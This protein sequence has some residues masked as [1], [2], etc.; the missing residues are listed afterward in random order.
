MIR[1]LPSG[2]LS[3]PLSTRL[4][5]TTCQRP[6]RVFAH[7][8][9]WGTFLRPYRRGLGALAALSLVEIVLRVLAPFALAIVIDSALGTSPLSGWLTRSL[10]A[11]GLAT[12]RHDLLVIFAV[13]G[14]LL[15]LLHQLVVMFH[16]Q[17]S[18]TIGQGMIRDVRERLFAHMQALTLKHHAATPT[19]EVAQ[20]LEGDTRCID[21][22]LLRGV[23]PVA[24]SALTL[25]IMFCILVRI[26]VTLGLLSLSII[27]PLYVWLRFYARRMAS[28]ADH[29]RRT[30]SRLSSRLHEIFVS[31][32]LVKSHA[33]EDH[34]QQRFSRVAGDAAHAWIHV[35]RQGAV[36]SIVN[37]VLTVA[38]STLILIIGGV[39]VLDGRMS[40][41]TLMLV[42]TYLGYVYGPMQAIANT[43]G[44]MQQALASA[45]RIREAFTVVPETLDAPS[46]IAASGI[47]GTV[48]FEDVSFAYVPGMPVLDHVT[49][50]ARPGDMIALVGPSGAGKT[51]LASLLVRFYDATA[52]TIA[53][54][55]VPIEQYRLGSL[56][57]R[58]AIVLQEAV[59]MSGTIRDNLRYGCLH[60][61]ESEMIA[62]A[63][64]ANAD[65]FIAQLP[66]GYD[67]VLG[68]AGS[69]LS[70]GQRQRLSIA[71]A[72]LK[73]APIL[74]LDEPT[75]ALD[76]I[77]EQQVVD[78]VR[79]LWAG[80]TTF[81]I[82]HRLSTVRE[83]TRIV[84]MDKG[85]ITAEGKHDELRR[86][87][88]LYR[89]LASQLTDTPT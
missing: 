36:F 38:G 71:R 70:G 23:F 60:A 68:E 39:A 65:E 45:R 33:R 19:G 31:I 29:A 81:V 74:I 6:S 3:L 7:G 37:G 49:F 77:S 58:I 30:D 25:L 54:D 63:R 35:G 48:A 11:L 24:F 64:A 89:R 5:E 22:L 2:E 66:L 67:T 44:G 52:G 59:M 17:L 62:A 46:A 53:I 4:V 50:T 51:T 16:G 12:G 56:R 75:A 47:R 21:Q 34:E 80:R 79:R 43:S 41:G 85:R 84:V 42:L 61:S 69:G 27:P 76:T 57:Q 32:R 28:P 88:D 20:R 72:F 13:V 15:Q 40:I 10:D 26:D 87:N 14:L 86:T 9:R 55:G 18:V 8:F 1:G 82:A 83:A 78:A 73:D